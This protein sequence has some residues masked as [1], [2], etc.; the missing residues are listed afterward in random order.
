MIQNLFPVGLQNQPIVNA[1]LPE[2]NIRGVLSISSGYITFE[3]SGF[4][5]MNVVISSPNGNPRITIE[6][7][8]DG[9]FWSPIQ[10]ISL[11][12][13]PSNLSAATGTL[14]F[15][16]TNGVGFYQVAKPAQFI[17]ISQGSTSNN[18]YTTVNVILYNGNVTPKQQDLRIPNSSSWYFVS[19]PGGITNT[20]PVHLTA[21]PVGSF[22]N[23]LLAINITNSGNIDTE[24]LI[25]TNSALDASG[26]TVLYRTFLKAGT[27]QNVNFT[28][29]LRT[30][31][32]QFFEVVVLEATVVYV[33]AQ[34]IIINA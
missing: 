20:E 9:K 1:K 18:S 17:R 30:L 14:A 2:R 12:S 28:P 33:N 5:A 27:T 13:V 4:N 11:S 31:L 23:A 3:T 26:P 29:A 10:P 6:G 19:P 22:Q 7:S 24:F 32:N 8:G 34:G 16:N 15:V 21:W 25:R